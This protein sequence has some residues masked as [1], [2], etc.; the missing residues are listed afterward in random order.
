MSNAARSSTGAARVIDLHLHIEDVSRICCIGAGRVGILSMLALA[1]HWPEITF[2]VLDDDVEL[3]N[4]I[5]DNNTFPFVEPGLDHLLFIAH[6]LHNNVFFS[7]DTDME[8]DMCQVVFIAVDIPLSTE[9]TQVKGDLNIVN[10]ELALMDILLSIGRTREKKYVAIKSTMPVDHM[11]DLCSRLNQYPNHNLLHVIVNPEFFTEGFAVEELVAPDRVVLGRFYNEGLLLFTELYLRVVNNNNDRIEI[12]DSIMS[13]ELGK[14]L[15]DAIMAAQLTL[16]NIGSTICER[17]SCNFDDVKRTIRVNSRVNGDH[18]N[19]RSGYGGLGLTKDIT[20]LAYLCGSLGLKD[21]QKFFTMITGMRKKKMDAFVQRIVGMMGIATKI[22]IF[23]FSNKK[24]SDDIRESPAIYISLALLKIRE[25]ELTIVDP[26]IQEAE[27]RRCF[28]RVPAHRIQVVQEPNH[29]TWD[30]KQAMIFLV[31]WLD[32]RTMLYQQHVQMLNS[33]GL[34]KIILDSCD[35][36]GDDLMLNPIFAHQAT[37]YRLGK[38][39]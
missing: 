31:D 10:L 27:I 28:P 26:V 16:I 29:N 18:I 33:M 8:L 19:S 5:N 39:V 20:Y 11:N 12:V 35:I 38:P 15:S 3:I 1:S 25:V 36:I 22:A 2:V 17:V 24:D 4:N 30:E 37:I 9:P 34:P 23:G 7:H 14:L 21:E 32:F 13:V 6:Q